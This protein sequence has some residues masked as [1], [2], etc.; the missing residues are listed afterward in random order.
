[1]KYGRKP[2][3]GLLESTEGAAVRVK[4]IGQLNIISQHRKRERCFWNK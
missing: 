3:L 4:V 1:M 2:K